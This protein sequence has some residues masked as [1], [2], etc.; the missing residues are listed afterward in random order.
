MTNEITKAWSG[1]TIKDY[2]QFKG[3]KKENLKDNMT[4]LELVLNMLAEVSTKELS[5]KK[6]P[7][8][9]AESNGIAK[10]GGSVAKIAKEKLESQLGEKVVSKKNAKEIHFKDKKMIVGKK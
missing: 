4:N 6:D 3:L 9:F 2:K 1:K 5:E 10:K 8:T 7:K